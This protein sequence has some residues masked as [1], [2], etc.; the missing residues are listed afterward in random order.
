MKITFQNV[1]YLTLHIAGNAAL[2]R[3]DVRDVA[4]LLRPWFAMGVVFFTLHCC[5]AIIPNLVDNV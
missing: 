5:L 1:N 2:E 4:L 3:N